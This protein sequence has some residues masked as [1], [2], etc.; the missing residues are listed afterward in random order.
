[1]KR[2]F[3]LVVIACV[4]AACG[5]TMFLDAVIG[6][7]D[8]IVEFTATAARTSI[9][10]LG[11]PAYSGGDGEVTAYER[12]FM[13]FLLPPNWGMSEIQIATSDN[14]GV[15]QLDS[16]F[17]PGYE[18]HADGS[19]SFHATPTLGSTREADNACVWYPF[20]V[21][22]MVAIYDPATRETYYLPSAP[23]P[24]RGYP[25]PC[26]VPIV[27]NKLYPPQDAHATAVAQAS[28]IEVVIKCEDMGRGTYAL[29]VFGITPTAYYEFVLDIASPGSIIATWEDGGEVQT[30]S[31]LIPVDWFYS[32]C[33]WDVR[34]A[35]P[36][37]CEEGG[38]L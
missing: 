27:N 38:H 19:V 18:R 34:I 26:N 37:G 1:M 35:S 25:R 9:F 8:V 11:E 23:T 16:I 17:F 12:V 15:E 5:C 28:S 32:T 3:A 22:T 29:D 2:A 33:E 7:G 20:H 10:Q 36:G 31:V 4:L 6:G 21:G 24:E 13:R 30:S 14:H